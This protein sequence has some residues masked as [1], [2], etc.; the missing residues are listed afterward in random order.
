[1]TWIWRRASTDAI[2]AHYR[3]GL[4]TQDLCNL[5]DYY[6]G[7]AA[8]RNGPRGAPSNRAGHAHALHGKDSESL[9]DV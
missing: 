2:A 7:S 1:M 8:C 5:S 4:V 3:F 9:I 6:A